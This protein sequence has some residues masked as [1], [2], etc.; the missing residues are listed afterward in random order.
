MT[1]NLFP[2][3]GNREQEIIGVYD[4]AAK[5]YEQVG[6]RAASY[7]GK[8]LV[9]RLDIPSGARVLDV[10][11]GRGALLFPA[12]QQ[13]GPAGRV[14]GIDLAPGMVE[15]TTAEIRERGLIQAEV[16]QM[17]GNH[18][19]FPDRS[20][21]DIL[22]GFAL[23]FLDYPRALVRF[24]R[25]LKPEGTFAALVPY[26]PMEDRE[27]MERWQWLFSLTRSVFPP[28]FEPPTAWT[29]PNRLN[30]P[31][32]IESAL[33][34]AGYAEIS[35]WRE[36]KVMY[37]ADEDD[38]WAWEWSQGSRFWLEGM[39][40]EGLAT[41]KTVAFEKLGQMK[42]VEGIPMLQGALFAIG[43]PANQSPLL[44]N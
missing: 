20:F 17:D 27:N 24:R 21:N 43:K 30:T 6:I 13:V 28:G 5:T 1:T 9:E 29:A 8:H 38:W 19:A 42:V 33:Q 41:F 32:R 36:E 34:E 44:H 10:A 31:E 15:A 3:E 4:R 18:P 37:F 7:F 23:H 16:H 2:S 22:C 40:P 35:V 12:A 26:V 39:S 14:I 25:L 11:T